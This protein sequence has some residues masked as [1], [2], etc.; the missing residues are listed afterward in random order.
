MSE[1]FDAI[2]VGMGP[3]GEVAAS[4]LLKADQRVAIIE[5]ELIGGECG[6]WACIPSKTLLRPPEAQHGAAQAAGV[7]TPALDWPQAAEYR[8]TMIRH[9]DDSAQVSGYQDKGATVV[10]GPGSITAPGTVEADGRTLQAERIIVATGSD[11]AVPPIDGLDH[12]GAWTN[13]EAT[14]LTEIPVR[15]LV[16]GG[17]AVGVELAQMLARFGSHV[18]LVELADQLV[19]GE[20]PKV[21]ELSAA[22][23]QDDGIDIRV[24][25]GVDQ[26]T[27]N[28]SST[29]ARLN[30][31]ATVDVDQVIVATGRTARI[32]GLGLDAVGINADQKGIPIDDRCRAGDGIWAIGDVTGIMQLTHV[33]KYQARIAVDNILGGNRR[34]DY[35]GIPRV[36]FSDPE[37]AAAGM[38][39]Q[40]AN[41]QGHHVA[42]VTVE[43]PKTLARPWTYESEPRGEMGLL[44]DTGEDVLLGAWAVAPLAGEWIHLAS[45]AIR[46]RLGVDHLL[47]FVAQFPT[48]TESYLLGVEQALKRKP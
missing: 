19:P 34:I 1:R 23:L 6:Y 44:V 40:Q 16:L 42:H 13:R 43:L 4:E 10:K 12:V 38:T 47:D 3:G 30:D 41:E 39:E 21:G 17:S 35:A 26:F 28:G 25:S 8:D 14:T 18:T 5:R 2:V 15:S 27:R 7:A 24:G 45:L 36:I 32:N 11:A 29:T 9:L 33:A 31:G 20:E 22:F 46:A 48:Y 37:I